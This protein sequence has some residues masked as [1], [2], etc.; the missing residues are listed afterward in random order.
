[1]DKNA[2]DVYLETEI[3]TATAQKLRLTLIEGGLRFARQTLDH[4]ENGCDLEAREAC[5]RCRMVLLELLSSLK[6]EQSEIASNTADIYLFLIRTVTQAE[7]DGDP[8]QIDQVI[9]VLELERGTWQEIC[10]KFP[11]ETAVGETREITASGL[12]AIPPADVP[13]RREGDGKSRETDNP[14]VYERKP[15]KGVTFDG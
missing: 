5:R 2:R 15:H 8:V 14:Y 12:K 4:W 13:H 11:T 3:A 6:T 9:R 1:M 10:V 7:V